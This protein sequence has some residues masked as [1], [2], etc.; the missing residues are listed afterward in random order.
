LWV[1]VGA[2]SVALML[3]CCG[4]GMSGLAKLRTPASSAGSGRSL[5]TPDS[6]EDNEVSVKRGESVRYDDLEF[7]ISAPPDCK[8]GAAGQP[9]QQITP[10]NGQFCNVRIRVT[11]RGNVEETWTSNGATAF[12]QREEDG[13]EPRADVA[14]AWGEITGVSIVPGQSTT[15]LAVFDMEP[16]DHIEY[17]GLSS[18]GS[19]TKPVY[20]DM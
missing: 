1:A 11:N 9:G 4:M 2:V 19:T 5:P 17:V 16:G 15:V 6:G 13:V 7:L 8:A 18:G 10:T 20:V 12:T 3:G 14:W